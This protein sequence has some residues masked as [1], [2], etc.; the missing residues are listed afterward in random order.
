MNPQSFSAAEKLAENI[1]VGIKKA[2]SRLNV[3]ICP[4]LPWLTT[5]AKMKK[6]IE[7]GA[8]DVFWEPEGAYTG[9]VSPKMLK[10]SGVNYVIVGHSERRE[11][12]G[13]T[14]EM[15]N[16]KVKA[17]LSL[18]LK[19]VLCVGER[20]RSDPNFQDFVKDELRADLIGISGRSAKYLLIAYEPLW[21]IG[22]GEAAEPDDIFEMATYIRRNIF[23][24]LGKKAA[25]NTPILYGGSVDHENAAGF[26]HARGVN[27]LL[28]GSASL[29]PKEFIGIVSAAAKYEL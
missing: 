11:H 5:L 19:V 8:Q 9:E 17:A 28:V 24:I 22:T 23:D 13:E 27:G 12:L 25:Y 4:P 16:K 1:L 26:L 14:D 3:V 15:I 20:S 21:A 10:N 29:E 2:K 18:G 6:K 7:W